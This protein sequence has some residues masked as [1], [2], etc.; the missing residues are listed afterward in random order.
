MKTNW[1]DGL[2]PWRQ[3]VTPEDVVAA[4]PVTTEAADDPDA[5]SKRANVLMD[6]GDGK[7]KALA[8]AMREAILSR[9]M[10]CK[11]EPETSDDEDE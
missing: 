3:P 7:S 11:P 10:C 6:K 1:K 2:P 8:K 5:V 4:W 9:Y